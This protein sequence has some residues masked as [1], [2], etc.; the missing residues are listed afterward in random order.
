MTRP[1]LAYFEDG[2]ASA[3]ALVLLHSLATHSE[4]WLGQVP[5][6]REA[7]RL[8][9]ID[10]PGHGSSPELPAATSLAAI[11]GHVLD[12]LDHLGV[13]K[14]AF[15]G[16]SLGGMVAQAVALDHPERVSALVIAHAGA[17]TDATVRDIWR[18][19]L[20]QFE[21]GGMSALC[22]STLQRWFPR[23]FAEQA[24]MT[25]RW[26]ARLIRA[27]RPGGYVG[28]IRA[29]QGLDHLERL[30]GITVPT[31]VVAGDADAAVPAAV[32]AQVAERIAGARTCFLPDTGHIGNVQSPTLFTEAVGSFLLNATST[33]A[34]GARQ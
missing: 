22:E 19:R 12:V 3:P 11:A 26:V 6:W 33:W 9:R 8:I 5:V 25:M 2:A 16:L 4:L 7:F 17:R 21:A 14:A 18:Q 20:E 30:N 24:P 23:Q 28:A 1:A 13:S 10:L 27:T 15:V 29:I 32:A 31:L 34:P